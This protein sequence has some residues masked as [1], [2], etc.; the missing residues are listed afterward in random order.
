MIPGD[1]IRVSPNLS[2]Q[3]IDGREIKL[4]ELR[5]A[6]VMV[7]F[8][9]TTCSTC[10]KKIPEL[11]SLYNKF[12][13]L[14]MEIIAIAMSYDPPN[15]ILSFSRDKALPYTVALD[16]DGALARAFNEVD[17]TPS[18]FLIDSDGNVVFDKTGDFELETLEQKIVDLLNEQQNQAALASS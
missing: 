4:S 13:P 7:T 16:L 6:P 3:V 18:T 11:K 5:G 12:Q 8:W 1:Q 14:G 17:M 2:F 9:A 10:V 15:R